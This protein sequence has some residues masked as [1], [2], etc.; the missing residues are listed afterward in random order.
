MTTT[1]EIL[2]ALPY[3]ADLSDEL[4]ESVCSQSEQLRVEPGEVIIEEGSDSEEMYLVAEGE[5]VVSKTTGT[6]DVELARLGP[7]EVVGEIAL[8]DK[9]LEP[10]P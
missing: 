6:R 4:I 7:G 9:A 5:L 10:Q 8:L 2:R 1:A 3:F